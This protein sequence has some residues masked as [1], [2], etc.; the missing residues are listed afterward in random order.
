MTLLKTITLLLIPLLFSL[1]VHACV[2]GYEIKE[3][4]TCLTITAEKW[5][6]AIP[7]STVIADQ[8]LVVGDFTTHEKLPPRSNESLPTARF[9]EM[10][11]SPTSDRILLLTD[12]WP[13]CGF[14]LRSTRHSISKVF[15]PGVLLLE[16]RRKDADAM[17]METESH[18]S[19]MRIMITTCNERT[20]G[21]RLTP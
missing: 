20:I 8:V 21:P 6:N 13:Q 15:S 12:I 14:S 7:Y 16:A 2:E 1:P 4:K 19:L 9:V 3:G 11:P 17:L 18:R 10:S 5:E